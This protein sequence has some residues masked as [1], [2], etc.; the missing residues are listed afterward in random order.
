[1]TTSLNAP[2]NVCPKCNTPKQ[3]T[4]IECS[5]CGVVFS[6][7][8]NNE[9]LSNKND[10]KKI[11]IAK[12]GKVKKWN[13]QVVNFCLGCLLFTMAFIATF[14]FCSP[15][16]SD[17]STTKRKSYAYTPSCYSLGFKFGKCATQAFLGYEC[18]PE[19]DI[20]IPGRCRGL[21]ETD[22]GIRDGT[23]MVYDF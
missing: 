5:K 19:D 1:M 16:T 18:S 8:Q 7:I 15:D 3:K 4:D 14:T 12:R 21:S 6:K 23:K 9:V 2:K 20:I 10:L 13:K 22:R 17:N 11:E